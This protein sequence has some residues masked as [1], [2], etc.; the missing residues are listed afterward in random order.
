MAG[1]KMQIATS[2]VKPEGRCDKAGHVAREKDGAGWA[3]GGGG[4]PGA[5]RRNLLFQTKFFHPFRPL[6]A[7]Q[8]RRLPDL[9]TVDGDRTDTGFDGGLLA[10]REGFVVDHGQATTGRPGN[11]FEDEFV[12]RRGRVNLG[13]AGGKVVGSLLAFLNL[14][15]DSFKIRGSR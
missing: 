13:P 3:E 9:N 10:R 12:E 1:W 14:L 6:N 4:G 2:M 5:N 11:A 15:G 7:N 8:N